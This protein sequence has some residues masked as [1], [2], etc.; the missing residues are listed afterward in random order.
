MAFSNRTGPGVDGGLG[1]LLA[2]FAF[3]FLLWISLPA[4]WLTWLFVFSLRTDVRVSLWQCQAWFNMNLMALLQ[5]FVFRLLIPEPGLRYIRWAEMPEIPRHIDPSRK[6]EPEGR[7]EP[8][9]GRPAARPAKVRFFPAVV[10]LPLTLTL[11]GI[12]SLVTDGDKPWLA[13]MLFAFAL[14][15]GVIGVVGYRRSKKR[16]AQQG[17][18]PQ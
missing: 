13:Y 10:F 4:S 6:V 16:E 14:V 7:A 17:Q 15:G 8:G 3:G 12:A 11:A 2:V 18:P 5:R 1:S 9:S